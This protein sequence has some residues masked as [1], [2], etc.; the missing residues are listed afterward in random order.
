MTTNEYTVH[1]SVTM[2]TIVML[3]LKPFMATYTV[4]VWLDGRVHSFVNIREV[5]QSRVL[6]Q[7]LRFIHNFTDVQDLIKSKLNTYDGNQC[8]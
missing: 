8:D 5:V 2:D 7:V 4:E 6:W 3:S 1:M